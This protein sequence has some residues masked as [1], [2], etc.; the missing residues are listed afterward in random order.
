MMTLL[1]DLKVQLIT[2][3]GKAIIQATSPYRVSPRQMFREQVCER[4][5]MMGQ[6][7]TRC[8]RLHMET[9]TQGSARNMANTL[10]ESVCLR[11]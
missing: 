4:F 10:K 1:V 9:L 5:A 11:G 6:V 2:S 7:S 8:P 3:S